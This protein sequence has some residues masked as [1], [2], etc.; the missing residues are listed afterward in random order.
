M[1]LIGNVSDIIPN[2]LVTLTGAD[3]EKMEYHPALSL[4]DGTVARPVSPN[5]Y[6]FSRY[7]AEDSPISADFLGQWESED[8]GVV[9]SSDGTMSLWSGSSMDQATDQKSGTF[10]VISNSTQY[11]AGA[12]LFELTDDMIPL[13]FGGFLPLPLTEQPSPQHT[14]VGIYCG[15]RKRY[16]LHNKE[17]VLLQKTYPGALP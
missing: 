1:V 15:E 9:F 11:P 4:C 17:T 5:V 16:C 6:D 7:Q 2:L 14:S 10:Y 12:V 3:G 8:G 13:L